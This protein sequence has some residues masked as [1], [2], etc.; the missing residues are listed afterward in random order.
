M[1]FNDVAQNDLLTLFL[2]CSAKGQENNGKRRLLVAFLFN[3]ASGSPQTHINVDARVR[4]SLQYPQRSTTFFL[5]GDRSFNFIAVHSVRKNCI[6]I[7]NK[8]FPSIF[9]EKGNNY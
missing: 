5:G 1:E 7:A 2:S 4:V 9:I 6:Y 8:P 3:L